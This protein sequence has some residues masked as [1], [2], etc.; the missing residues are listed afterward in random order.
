MDAVSGLIQRLR[1]KT[2]FNRNPVHSEKAKKRLCS[3]TILMGPRVS[4]VDR[5][6]FNPRIFIVCYVEQGN[7]SFV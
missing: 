5:E 4:F 6:S 1:Q 7:T 2:G 3:R